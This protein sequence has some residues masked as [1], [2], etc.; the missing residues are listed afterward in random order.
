MVL[1]SR[2]RRSKCLTDPSSPDEANIC[3]SLKQMSYTAESCAINCVCTHWRSMFQM[4]HV[5]SMELVPIM[6]GYAVFQSNEVIGA[7]YSELM[8]LS[9]LCSLNLFVSSCTSHTRKYSAVVASMSFLVPFSSG[10]HMILV[11]GNSCLNSF[12]FLKP[13][14]GLLN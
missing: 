12:I 11:G 4:V 13:S 14:L 9:I 2:S 10:I 3:S 1:C 6:F 7:Q 8:F 5:V